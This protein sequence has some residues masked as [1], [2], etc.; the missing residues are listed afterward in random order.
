MIGLTKYGFLQKIARRFGLKRK[1]SRMGPERSGSSS[2]A[3]AVL[4]WL[5]AGRDQDGHRAGHDEWGEAA[6]QVKSV[7]GGE[8]GGRDAFAR[9]DRVIVTRANLAEGSTSKDCASSSCCTRGCGLILRSLPPQDE[10]V[11]G[12]V[13][14]RVLRSQSYRRTCPADTQSVHRSSSQK[15]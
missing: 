3:Q 8:W 4:A 2:T 13:R 5:A 14:L 10:A 1:S 12:G 15:I 6:S 7:S 9:P 11:R